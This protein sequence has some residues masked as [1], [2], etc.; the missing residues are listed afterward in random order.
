MLDMIGTVGKFLRN[1]KLE[2]NVEKTK[3]LVFNKLRKEKNERW[4]WGKKSIEEVQKFKYLDFIF[5]KKG[6]YKDQIKELNKKG[7]M[8]ANR[9]WGLK[10]RIC[11]DDFVRWI[12]FKYL[13][14]SV[15]AYGVEIWG[16]KEKHRLEKILLDYIRW[17]FRV[18]FCTPRYLVYRELATEKLMVGWGIRAR[19]F[20]ERI[21]EGKENK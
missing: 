7:R 19:R 12:L 14:Q 16:W 4:R 3:L 15:M 20:E 6:N 1:R 8:A 11:K 10:E 21:R 13:V 5:D 18:D 2:L 17:I 9:V